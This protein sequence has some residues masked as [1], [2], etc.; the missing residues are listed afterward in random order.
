MATA[1]S[2]DH[3]RF[4]VSTF[5]SQPQRSRTMP[6]EVERNSLWHSPLFEL[7]RQTKRYGIC[8]FES[9]RFEVIDQ[10]YLLDHLLRL[11]PELRPMTNDSIQ[12]EFDEAL[13]E[14]SPGPTLS[15]ADS[16]MLDWLMT[17]VEMLDPN[18]ENTVYNAAYKGAV[19][20]SGTVD[21]VEDF[22]VAAVNHRVQLPLNHGVQ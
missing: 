5:A 6:I 17:T 21:Q 20:F 22:M 7:A 12:I 13:E 19:L 11:L 4:D 9:G 3:D 2:H 8:K 18:G 1:V 15:E 16:S 10:R 14:L